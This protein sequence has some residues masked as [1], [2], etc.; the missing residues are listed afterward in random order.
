MKSNK[1]RSDKP[2]SLA[3]PRSATPALVL[4]PRGFTHGRVQQPN[5]TDFRGLLGAGFT[6]QAG[7]ETVASLSPN[8]E[9]G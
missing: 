6:V 1:L 2:P 9:T 5:G 3:H 4:R 7:V 8:Q